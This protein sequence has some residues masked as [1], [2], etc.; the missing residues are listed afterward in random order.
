VS[1]TSTSIVE[2]RQ[3]Q[4]A[5]VTPDGTLSRMV[6]AKDQQAG[7]TRASRASLWYPL[8]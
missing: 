6:V 8:F 4:R 2:S 3:V 7:M 1:S 5:A